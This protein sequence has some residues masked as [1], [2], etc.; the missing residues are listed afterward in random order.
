MP[1]GYIVANIRV[2]DA[3]TFKG[4]GPLS[5]KAIEKYNGR[6]LVRNPV[7]EQREGESRGVAVVV[8]FDDVETARAF[9]ESP[10][11]TEARRLRDTCSSTDLII[12]E[13]V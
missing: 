9:Y 1:K 12:V 4:F 3:E 10:E 11:Y 6:V 7:S 8:E 2:T 5:A 13:G